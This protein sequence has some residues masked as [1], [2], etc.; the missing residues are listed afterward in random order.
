MGVIVA[1]LS[2]LYSENTTRSHIL[3]AIEDEE[4]PQAYVYAVLMF[5]GSLLKSQCD[6]N[7]LWFGRRAAT[8]TRSELMAVIYDKALKRRDLSGIAKK[9]EEEKDEGKKKKSD[10]KS[11]KDDTQ[12]KDK[13]QAGAD[14]GK[15]VNLMA[16]DAN[17]VSM[18]ITAIYFLYNGMFLPL[19]IKLARFNMISSAPVEIIIGVLY[20]YR[21]LGISALAGLVVLLAGWPLNTYLTK[22]GMEIYKGT[23]K[24]RDKRM[25]VVSELIGAVIHSV[26]PPCT[27]LT[28]RRSSSSSS[29]LGSTSG[30]IVLWRNERRKYRGCSKENPFLGYTN[31]CLDLLF[32]QAASTPSCFTFSGRASQY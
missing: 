23:A 7:H 13:E 24:V 27:Q 28:V 4:R 12:D 31:I 19:S 18:T 29:L 10:D 11:K 16:G 25:G 8:R 32:I 5:L 15:I 30:S 9:A 20:L 1:H 2:R 26:G 17:R 21:L 6:V 3:S 14:I 22:R